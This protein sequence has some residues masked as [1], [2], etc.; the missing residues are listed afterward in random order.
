MN[1]YLFNRA[2][3]ELFLLYAG[4]GAAGKHK[5]TFGGPARKNAW[6]GGGVAPPGGVSEG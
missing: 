4:G 3:T 5:D 6:P 1:A 2:M